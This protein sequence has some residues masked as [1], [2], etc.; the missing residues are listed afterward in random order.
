MVKPSFLSFVIASEAW[1][2]PTFAMRLLRSWRCSQRQVGDVIA[3]ADCVSIAMTEGG[4]IASEAR[5]SPTFAMRL[6]RSW[7]PSQRQVG[8]VIASA[9]CVSLAMTRGCHCEHMKGARQSRW[10][11]GRVNEAKKS[12]GVP[13]L[14]DSSP[15]VGI[16]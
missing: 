6:L 5:Q 16:D 12:R 15:L 2:S 14:W 1:Q 7:R 9:D 3:S 11:E 13:I 8:D 10:V 4:V